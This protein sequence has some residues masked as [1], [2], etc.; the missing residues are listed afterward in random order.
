MNAIRQLIARRRLSRELSEEI[1]EHLAETIE[2]LVENGM[3]AS[4]AAAAAR[5]QFGNVTFLEEGARE[6]WRWTMLEDILADIR[7]AF[8]QLRK[9]PVFAIAAISTLAVGVGADTAV[10]SVVNAVMLR[11]LPYA[12]P[13]R[14]VSVAS[15]S[16]KGVPHPEPALSYPTFFDFR[17]LNQVFDH[18]V[19]YRDNQYTMGAPERPIHVDGEI[20]S[21]DLF[22]A[23]GV[24][25]EIGR[26]FLPEEEK[27]G[28]GAVVLSHQLW[29]AQFGGDRSLV[30]KSITID[31]RPHTV[32]GIA[33]PGFRFPAE[34][35]LAQIWTTIATDA[36][37]QMGEP[38]TE[39]RGA[40]L[41]SATGRLKPG[42]AIEQARAQM[43]LVAG[44]LAQQHPENKNL[45]ATYI[46]PQL[47]VLVGNTRSPLLVLLAAVGLVLLI[48]CANIASLLLA[49]TAERRHEFCVRAAIG[50][51]RSRIVRQLLAESMVLALLGCIAGLILAFASLRVL[52]PLAGDSIP[53]ISQASLDGRVLGF[54]I[55]LATLTSVL[56]SLAPALQVAQTRLTDSLKQ[57]NRGGVRGS[58]RLRSILVIGQ[59][60]LGL[61]LLSGA[62][63]LIASFAHLARQDPGVKTDHVLTFGVNLPSARYNDARSVSFYDQLVGRLKAL[64]GA[65]S[66]AAGNPLP[67]TGDQI[68]VSFDIEERP[69]PPAS[70]PHADMAIVT[71]GYFQTLGIPTVEGRDFL[72][73]DDASA[74]PVL[75][76][77]R[78]FAD[79]FF[80]GEQVV[81]KRIRPGATGAMGQTTNEIVGLVGNARQ[82]ALV[83]EPE[84]IYYFSYKQLT[85]GGLY[86][87][88]RTST[89]PA[90]VE[91]SVREAVASIDS[92]E[93]VFD[94][95]TLD[96]LKATDIAQPRFQML[97]LAS[98]AGVALL[99]IVVGLYG[100]LAYS[101]MRRTREIGLRIALGATGNSVLRMVLAKTLAMVGAGLVIG[102]AA[103]VAGGSLLQEM[104]YGAGPRDPVVFVV[105]CLL[106][107]ATALAAAYVPARRASKVDPVQALRTE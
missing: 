73:R 107:T 30:G 91:S 36:T 10:F 6:V 70:R 82:S 25:P 38:I 8:R 11:P 17:A 78:A 23:L 2:A 32:A 71:P 76:V 44:A 65:Q 72:P 40:R 90:A 80:P 62:S 97:L 33:P 13:D 105:A 48:A 99:L 63:L 58:D 75:I 1:Q 41:L 86:G 51:S 27:P 19:C 59:I 37:V 92:Q 94:L 103:S 15:W 74:P 9:S 100:L 4:E 12:Q 14:L 39:Q 95:K 102:F 104:L 24:Q 68:N 46:Q 54:S 66:A 56:F 16:I 67:F 57:D 47:A 55:A 22:P 43:D 42:V 83:A 79:K 93:P 89:P 101:V 50:A 49:R 69:T 106:I 77:N 7:Y 26:G 34:S 20:V 52:L 21:W 18:L 31:G 45:P 28:S 53:R 84:P 3:S 60:A 81:G 61:V 87:V 5:R 96:E 35:N 64:P 85:W 88:L 98:F 29:Q